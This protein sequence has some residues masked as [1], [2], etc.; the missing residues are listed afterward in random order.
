[1]NIGQLPQ[2][3][4]LELAKQL[5]V[6][7]LLGFLSTCRVIR[8]LQF[9]RSLWL[10]AL[11]RIRETG[12]QPL[13]LSTADPPDTLSLRELQNI[14]R[15][16][17]RLR[18]NLQS[19]NPRLFDMRSLSVVARAGLIFFIPG[20]HLAVTHGPGFVTCWDIVSSQ[21][22]GQLEIPHLLVRD[23]ALSMDI[24][25]KA[26][27]GAC[28]TESG[29]LKHLV[30]ICINFQDRTHISVSHLISPATKD[31]VNRPS[32]FFID[33]HLV[34]FVEHSK[35]VFWCMKSDIAVQAAPQPVKSSF[36]AKCLPLGR[37]IYV[38]PWG[39]TSDGVVEV[40]PHPASDRRRITTDTAPTSGGTSFALQYPG[41]GKWTG[42]V[43]RGPQVFVP[44]YGIFAVTCRS[45][46]FEA[47][48][49]TFIHFRP[50]RAIRGDL[51]LSQGCVY[52]HPQ[53][54]AR[55]AVGAS[56]TYVLFLVRQRHQESYLGLVHFDA[57]PIPHTT[58]RKL[59]VGDAPLH[60][61]VQ[62]ALDDAL[63]LVLLVGLEGETTLL[64]YM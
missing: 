37:N 26:L 45:F 41:Q 23:E 52:E 62:I 36:R 16:A 17:D 14:A 39:S 60:S 24:S 5:N 7:D 22:V 58:F 49:T 11:S 46:T 56:G 54:I 48:Y 32:S 8:E 51:E 34:G 1:M 19:D 27:I 57:T 12:S 35:I 61:C 4:L 38:L 9:Q 64:S 15:R 47:A 28:I 50:G 33:S 3:V 6:R 40:I 21:M 44:D 30:V 31:T 25:G 43:E 2:D 18:R 20:A 53:S 42:C 13:P 29:M 59:D 55:M 10:E 63:G